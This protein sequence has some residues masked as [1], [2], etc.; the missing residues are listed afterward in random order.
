MPALF[1]FGSYFILVGW[2]LGHGFLVKPVYLWYNRNNSKAGYGLIF[3]GDFFM[4]NSP[5]MTY[6]HEYI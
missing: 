3:R 4:S 5:I 1:F 6:F 2:F